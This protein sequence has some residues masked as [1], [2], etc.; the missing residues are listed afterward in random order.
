MGLQGTKRT[1]KGDELPVT[2][3][4]LE[5]HDVWE[6]RTKW[7]KTSGNG[8][9]AGVALLA[10]KGFRNIVRA[11]WTPPQSDKNLEGRVLIVWF[12]HAGMDLVVVVAYAP[13]NSHRLQD[14][15]ETQRMWNWI[16]MNLE[17]VKQH[18]EVCILCMKDTNGPR[19]RLTCIICMT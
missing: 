9:L 13:C 12:S 5:N 19:N 11:V 15:K 7:K 18:A 14:Q 10:P 2:L 17:K 6:A 8:P 4:T 3:K 1:Y 16:S